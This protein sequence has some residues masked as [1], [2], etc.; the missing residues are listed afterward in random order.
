MHARVADI[1]L[2]I[3]EKKNSTVNL[4]IV[5]DRR[6]YSQV[7]QYMLARLAHAALLLLTTTGRPASSLAKESRDLILCLLIVGTAELTTLGDVL[8]CVSTQ[9]G[10]AHDRSS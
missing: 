7:A 10:Q 8:S 3:K 4:I 9:V 1:I 5:D 6:G 2:I